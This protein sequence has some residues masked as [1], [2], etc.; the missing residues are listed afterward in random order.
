M[1][2]IEYYRAGDVGRVDKDPYLNGLGRKVFDVTWMRTGLTCR[3]QADWT[4]RVMIVGSIPLFGDEV[5]ALPG[6]HFTCKTSGSEVYAAGD[7]GRVS[8]R[9]YKRDGEQQFDVT[10]YRTGLSSSEDVQ[11]WMKSL[12]VVGH[13]ISPDVGDEVTLLPGKSVEGV[14]S[15]EAVAV[16]KVTK[17]EDG[18]GSQLYHVTWRNGK[19]TKHSSEDWPCVLRLIADEEKSALIAPWEKEQ[20]E[21]ALANSSVVAHG[22]PAKLR[23]G[24]PKEAARGLYH[25][26]RVKSPFTEDSAA[27]IE[28]EVHSFV[29]SLKESAMLLELL[30]AKQEKVDEANRIQEFFGEEAISRARTDL[31]YFSQVSRAPEGATP[32]QVADIVEKELSGNLSYVLNEPAS[33]L[34]V[35]GPNAIRDKGRGSVSL[36]YFLEHVNVKL[37]ELAVPHVVALRFYTTT[38]FKYLNAPLRS[39]EQY[40][41]KNKPHPMPITMTYIAEGIKKLRT[42]HAIQ[43]GEGAMSPRLTLW[44]G[45]KSM[46]I[47]D[48]FLKDRAGGT[49]WAAMST[50]SSLEVAAKYAS[51]EDSILLKISLDNVMQYGADI[52]WLSAFP[53]ESEVLYPPLTYLQPTN[54]DPEVMRL[55]SGQRFTVYEVTPTIP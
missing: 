8:S 9:T 31:S 50:T 10:W 6:T 4:D 38:A 34:Y 26:M 43:V 37:A 51:S 49:E 41:D 14:S 3:I 52:Q 20:M 29:N 5:E 55:K 28:Q 54:R 47:A 7:R 32:L 35:T 24:H 16:G 25:M 40:Y 1:S 21:R 36:Q 42:A 45:L 48:D 19:T 13:A 46:H 12:N 23:S 44:R 2:G 17:T 53:G 11:S 27:Q 18:E 15:E 22:K 39:R 30:E 33:E